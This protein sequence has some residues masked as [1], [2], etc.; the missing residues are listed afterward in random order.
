MTDEELIK[1]LR[2]WR[3]NNHPMEAESYRNI[4]A[5]RIEELVADVAGWISNAQAASGW[6][7]EAEYKLEVTEAKLAKAMTFIKR[8][9]AAPDGDDDQWHI[10]L[11]DAQYF[12][13][14]LKK[15]K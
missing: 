7:S 6:A 13:A 1:V 11:A 8:I 15:T 5:D 14:E 4:A 10:M 12:I 9:L 2:D 3:M